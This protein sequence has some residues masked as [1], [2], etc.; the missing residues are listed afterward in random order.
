MLAAA[1]ILTLN[2]N[3]GTRR[4][5][6]RSSTGL[7][8]AFR[9]SSYQCLTHGRLNS[10]VLFKVPKF[11]RYMTCMP[12]DCSL[13]WLTARILN[14]DDFCLRYGTVMQLR[15]KYTAWLYKVR[16]LF[17]CSHLKTPLLICMNIGT[18]QK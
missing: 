16:S 7:S 4:V 17:D 18:D 2:H 6:R 11:C 12:A 9:A 8:I 1:L 10:S 3:T 13:G 14:S 15:K 5:K